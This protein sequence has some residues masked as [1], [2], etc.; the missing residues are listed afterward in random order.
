MVL[1]S[2]EG[3][4]ER[5]GFDKLQLNPFDVIGKDNFLLT[6]GDMSRFNTMTAGWGG[7]GYLWNKPVVFVFVRESRYTLEFLDRFPTFSLSFFS[8]EY[9]KMLDYCGSHSGRNGNKAQETGLSPLSISNT[10]AFEESNL[11]IAC[12][13]VSKILLDKTTLLDPS[14]LSHY[15]QG[16]YHYMYIGEIEGVYIN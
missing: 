1:C 13:K 5:I 15:P 6:S 11:V 3:D 9:S 14:L 4:M 16:D 8:Y 7:F 12:K 2:K 10:V